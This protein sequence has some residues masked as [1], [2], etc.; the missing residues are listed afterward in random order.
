MGFI[1]PA[2]NLTSRAA[3]FGAPTLPSQ[4]V[5]PSGHKKLPGVS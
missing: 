5:N 3:N 4:V 1:A 2:I